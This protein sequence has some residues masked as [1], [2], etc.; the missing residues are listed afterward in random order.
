[1]STDNPVNYNIYVYHLFRSKRIS[2]KFEISNVKMCLIKTKNE[3]FQICTSI[4][5]FFPNIFYLLEYY[6]TARFDAVIAAILCRWYGMW[7]WTRAFHRITLNNRK[8]RKSFYSNF[9][10]K[11]YYHNSYSQYKSYS[12]TERE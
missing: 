7:L 10:T 1:M 6:W 8:R 2:I 11:I 9:S 3:F 4:V 5:L 12:F